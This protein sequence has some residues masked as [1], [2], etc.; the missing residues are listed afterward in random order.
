VYR[1]IRIL[2][3]CALAGYLLSA[4]FMSAGG[5]YAGAIKGLLVGM[6]VAWGEWKWLHRRKMELSRVRQ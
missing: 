5:V 4:V 1:Y 3:L 2:A 6:L